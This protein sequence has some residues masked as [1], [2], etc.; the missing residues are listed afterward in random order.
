[1]QRIT[2]LC[3]GRLKTPWAFEASS[4]YIQRLRT[5]TQL[6][7]EELSASKEKDPDKQRDDESEKIMDRLEKLDG[8]VW[9]LDETGKAKTSEEFSQLIG[10]SKDRGEHLIFVVGGAYGLSSEVK[11]S[12]RHTLK[13]SDMTLPHELCRVLFLEQLYR[14]GEMLKGSGYHH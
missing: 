7:I 11:N 13:L 5:T 2:L 3:I 1:M 6:T 8:E 10:Q 12:A 9:V 4:Q 14:A